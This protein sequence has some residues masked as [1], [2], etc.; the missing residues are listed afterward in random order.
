MNSSLQKKISTLSLKNKSKIIK[1]KIMMIEPKSKM[2][3]LS[4]SLRT[5]RKSLSMMMV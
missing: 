3:M 1:K 4:Y 2:T 5:V